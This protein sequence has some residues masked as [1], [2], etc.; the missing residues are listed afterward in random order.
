MRSII[1]LLMLF[2]CGSNL[3]SYKIVDRNKKIHDYNEEV[4]VLNTP[5]SFYCKIHYKWEKVR[6]GY[7]KDCVKNIVRK[8]K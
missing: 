7:T 8:I 1:L 6:I 2:G 4:S 5:S 3:K